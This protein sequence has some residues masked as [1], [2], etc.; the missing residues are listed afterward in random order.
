VWED[1]NCNNI[2]TTIHC[3]YYVSFVRVGKILRTNM[4]MASRSGQ[5][6]T[7]CG[8]PRMGS[9]TQAESMMR[10]IRYL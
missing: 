8:G 5:S 4:E 3:I 10:N 7:L 6:G 1:S 2:F 9:E